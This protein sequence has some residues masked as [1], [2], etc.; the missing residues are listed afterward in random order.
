MSKENPDFTMLRITRRFDAPPERVFDAWVNPEMARKWLFK[1][2]EVDA[3][4]RRVE[5]DARLGG[6]YFITNRHEGTE[7]EAIGEYLEFNRPHRLVFTFAIPKLSPDSGRV[8]VEIVPD[9]TGCVLTL[10][11]ELPAEW[12]RATEEGWNKMF[13]A[14]ADDLGQ[15]AGRRA[16]NG[17]TAVGDHRSSDVAYGVAVEPTT[18]RFERL[19]PGPIER[20]WSYL[21][22]SDKRGQW[23][24]SGEIEPRVGA[25][26]KLHFHH[27]SLSSKPAPVP[28]RF[29][30]FENGVDSEHQVTRYEPPHVLSITW[31]EATNPS[32]VTFELAPEGGRVRLTLTHRRLANRTD[33]VGTAGGWHTHLGILTERLMGLDPRPFWTAF[34]E[35]DGEYEKRFPQD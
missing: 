35:I 26:F 14:L 2:K 8:M 12:H 17:Q 24:A 19:L 5:I 20:V 25:G 27:N 33:M 29:K 9:G 21:T 7:L 30:Q 28:E 15:S 10:T 31:G 23:L 22:E 6:S 34:L 1:S 4:E 11:H 16:G 32:E 3:F 13:D 18:V